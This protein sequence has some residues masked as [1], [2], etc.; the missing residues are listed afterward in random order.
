MSTLSTTMGA[1]QI[2]ENWFCCRDYILNV[3]SLRNFR[4]APE[5]RLL[6]HQGTRN[7]VMRSFDG[8][9]PDHLTPSNIIAVTRDFL[10]PRSSSTTSRYYYFAYDDDSGLWFEL[11]DERWLALRSQMR[12][13]SQIIHACREHK[14][15]HWFEVYRL[16]AIPRN[17]SPVHKSLS[18]KNQRKANGGRSGEGSARKVVG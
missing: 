2:H 9:P 15:V 8:H 6:L 12:R 1:G 18:H 7:Q 10:D 14:I 17:K 4:M 16:H 5:N 3:L 13:D 11:G